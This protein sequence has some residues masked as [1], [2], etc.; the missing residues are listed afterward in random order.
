MT[1]FRA[2]EAHVLGERERAR[3]KPE[4][5]IYSPDSEVAQGHF[6]S[7]P[8]VKTI[9]KTIPLPSSRGEDTDSRLLVRSVARFWRCMW[10]LK[11]R[12]QRVLEDAIYHKR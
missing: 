9:T 8:F 1:W 7:T 11:I 12:S 3:K 4:T 10:D 5:A 2:L 6:H